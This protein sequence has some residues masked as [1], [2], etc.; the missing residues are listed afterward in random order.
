MRGPLFAAAPAIAAPLEISGRKLSVKTEALGDAEGKLDLDFSLRAKVGDALDPKAMDQVQFVCEVAAAERV[1]VRAR[2]R[3]VVAS[4]A[5]GPSV[6]TRQHGD[7][8]RTHGRSAR[9]L[10]HWAPAGPIGS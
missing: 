7:V 4:R 8:A 10:T 5:R 6:P 2:R 1:D 9:H 3:E